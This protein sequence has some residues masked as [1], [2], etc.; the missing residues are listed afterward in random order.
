MLYENKACVIVKTPTPVNV[1]ICFAYAQKFVIL[2]TDNVN[3]KQGGD[4]GTAV[5]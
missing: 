1:I 2:L 4:M 3:R 5:G